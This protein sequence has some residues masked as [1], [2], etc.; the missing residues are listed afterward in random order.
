MREFRACVFLGWP[1]TTTRGLGTQLTVH[2]RCYV[3]A[4]LIARLFVFYSLPF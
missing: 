2:A 4:P 3:P 1:R